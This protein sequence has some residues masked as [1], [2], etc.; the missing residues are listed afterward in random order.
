MG[1]YYLTVSNGLTKHSSV[2]D[3]HVLST[4]TCIT[5]QCTE[6]NRKTARIQL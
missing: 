4:C 2:F 6:K 1:L 3:V 5:G